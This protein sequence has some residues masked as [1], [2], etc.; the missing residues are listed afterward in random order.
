MAILYGTT[1]DGETLPVEVN[2]FGQ[3]VAQG[4]PGEQGIQGPPGPP[5][6]VGSVDYTSGSWT[7]VFSST[8]PDGEGVFT[9]SA[10]TGWWYRFGP[11]L[12]VHVYLI[13]SELLLTNIRGNLSVAGLP[14]EARFGMES[15][16]SSAG[17]FSV[18]KFELNEYGRAAGT[19]VVYQGSSN[20]FTFQA[21]WNSTTSSGS[22]KWITPSFASLDAG[23]NFENNVLFTFSGVAAD[24]VQS[25]S[26]TLDDLV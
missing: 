24:A 17:P 18:A 15:T 19:R 4:V 16:I 21:F 23:G 26:S 10:Q 2:E 8:D 11:L 6:P 22:P 5:G 14:E 25:V 1:S 13:C 20:T 9:Y 7:P 3:L 12:T